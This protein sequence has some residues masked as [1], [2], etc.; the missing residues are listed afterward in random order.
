MPRVTTGMIVG[1]VILSFGVVLLLRNLGILPGRHTWLFWPALLVIF[2]IH[3][4]SR[5][6]SAS[7]QVWGLLLVA[8]G[9]YLGVD[10]LGFAPVP[11]DKLWPVL[12]IGLGML[13][14][15]RALRR[16]RPAEQQELDSTSVLNEFAM[17]GGVGRKINAPDFRGGDLFAAFGGHEIDLK[18]A[19]MNGNT[20]IIDANVIFG[21]ITIV[22]PAEWSV[23]VQGV[24]IF[25]G[26]EDSTIQPK[27]EP[28]TV[29]RRL[30]V[31][32]FAMFG[33][34]DVKN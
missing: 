2:G 33:G 19:G 3:N 12:L 11:I 32:G 34:V 10:D 8:A 15:W 20:A 4:L 22:V 27:L 23:S 7:S 28:G 17:F 25:G 1:L 18:Q 16:E 5:A 21:G 6:G 30:I 13:F 14:L 31:R 9:V 29:A 26:Y 24:A